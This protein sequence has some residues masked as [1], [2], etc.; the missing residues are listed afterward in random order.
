MIQIATSWLLLLPVMFGIG[1]LAS[2]WD[3]RLENRM[4][5]R[6]RMR[7]Q[8]STFKGLSL[9]LNEQPDQAIETLVK[10]AQLDPETIEGD[11]AEAYQ[12]WKHHFDKARDKIQDCFKETAFVP[13]E[14]LYDPEVHKTNWKSLIRDLVK[15]QEKY[16]ETMR[17]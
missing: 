6:E 17:T 15:N 2:R 4:D 10:I 3:L 1:W 12:R 7:Q 11:Y 16:N 13:F 14:P 9:L 5:E 8:R